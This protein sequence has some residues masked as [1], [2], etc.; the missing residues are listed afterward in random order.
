MKRQR[1]EE[2]GDPKFKPRFK[3]NQQFLTLS[4]KENKRTNRQNKIQQTDKTKYNI[5][6]DGRGSSSISIRMV[7]GLKVSRK[8]SLTMVKQ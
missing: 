4:S 3:C 6:P 2:E 8:A 5:F 1:E 7:F